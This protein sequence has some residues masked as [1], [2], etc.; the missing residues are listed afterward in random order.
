[1]LRWPESRTTLPLL[2]SESMSVRCR[3][4]P[5]ATLMGMGLE[6]SRR[7]LESRLEERFRLKK[8]RRRLI[9]S[10]LRSSAA[11]IRSFFSFFSFFSFRPPSLSL[12]F[13]MRLNMVGALFPGV[14][15]P[16]DYRCLVQGPCAPPLPLQTETERGYSSRAQTWPTNEH[17]CPSPSASYVPGALS[18]P[19]LSRGDPHNTAMGVLVIVVQSLGRIQLFATLTDCSTLGFHVL[20]YL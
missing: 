1:M 12:S 2:L 15:P 3:S 5:L 9:S 11:D 19:I 8:P 14:A 18:H 13:F 20:H 16:E 7:V 17:N 6:I 4:E 10:R